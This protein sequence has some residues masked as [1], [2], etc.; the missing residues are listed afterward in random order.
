[1]VKK[2]IDGV[3]GV[4]NGDE[5]RVHG[6]SSVVDAPLQFLHLLLAWEWGRLIFQPFCEALRQY[7]RYRIQG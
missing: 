6:G 3:Y 1:M 5:A 4:V 2:R 7:K